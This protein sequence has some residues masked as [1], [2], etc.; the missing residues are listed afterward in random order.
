MATVWTSLFRIDAERSMSALQAWT[1]LLVYCA[2]CLVLLVRKV[3]AP[4]CIAEPLVQNSRYNDGT[5]KNRSIVFSVV[6]YRA[7]QSDRCLVI[8]T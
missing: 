8:T 6:P 2:I 3:R 7:L 1:A 4:L 5:T